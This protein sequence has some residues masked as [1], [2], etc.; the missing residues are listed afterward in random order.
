MLD[1]KS[2]SAQGFSRYIL[3]YYHMYMIKCT[4]DMRQVG[5]CIAHLLRD[6]TSYFIY[7]Y[8]RV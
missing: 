1:L 6:K 7:P 3:E 5:I 8:K 4:A 2:I